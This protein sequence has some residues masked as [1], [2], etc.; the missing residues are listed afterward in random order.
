MAK[1]IAASEARYQPYRGVLADRER[2][3]RYESLWRK[4]CLSSRSVREYQA[5]LTA[6][7]FAL[8]VTAIRSRTKAIRSGGVRLRL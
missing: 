6:A 7:G 2:M 5:A 1:R 3:G 4:V 8:R